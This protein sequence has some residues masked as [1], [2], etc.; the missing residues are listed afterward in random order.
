MTTFDEWLAQHPVC[1]RTQELKECWEAAQAAMTI[2]GYGWF[3][4]GVLAGA[5]HERTPPLFVTPLYTPVAETTEERR[6]HE[7]KQDD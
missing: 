7:R 3:E 1:P 2:V 6:K 5:L 4:N